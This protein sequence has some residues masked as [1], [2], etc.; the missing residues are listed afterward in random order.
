[1]RTPRDTIDSAEMSDGAANGAVLASRLQGS[2]RPRQ[3]VTIGLGAIIGV[4]WAI[5]L[6]TWL[7]SAASAGAMLGFLIGGVL[8]LPI[9]AC[10]AELVTVIP[11]AGGEVVYTLAAFGR[12]VS[13]AT[14]WFIV[15]MT[16]SLSSFE[17]ISLAWF[18]DRLFP[19]VQSPV[20]YSL[21][22]ADVHYLSLA[23]GSLFMVI[24]TLVNYLGASAVGRFQDLFTYLKAVAIAV[25]VVAAFMNGNVDNLRP[26]WTPIVDRPAVIGIIWI[27]ATAPVFY[28][29]FQAIPQAVEERTASTSLATIGKLTVLPII[30]GV[31]F[32][33]LVIMASCLVVPWRTLA[34]AP[35]PAAL[36]VQ[37]A[38]ANVILA[39]AVLGLIVLGVLA[40]W[41]AVFLWGTRLMLALGRESMIPKVFART[42]RFQ[43]PGASVLFVGALGLVGL[44]LGR[45][46]IVP[47]INMASIS[48]AF[49]YVACCWAV[50]RLRRL[51]PHTARPFRVPLG[52]V[53]IRF[54]IG[55]AATM[56]VIVLL[57]PATRSHGM[58]LEWTL[59]LVWAALGFTFARLSFRRRPNPT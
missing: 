43:S 13:F 44:C 21:F 27:A 19:G 12:G 33:C 1:M 22:G 59:M 30:L 57:E 20:A 18:F 9:A 56:S 40:T 31:I 23:I 14:G 48:L 38:L 26:L 53:I 47:I 42:G 50:L 4:G 46:A 36:A 15:T 54:A 49:T 3:F 7:T 10:Y 55:S 45:G 28:G 11:S 2:L 35:L 8:M 39:K 34:A 24:I 16:T 29:G 17:G 37:T 32:Y 41:N 25:F 5:V 51:R 6:G 58:P 52:T